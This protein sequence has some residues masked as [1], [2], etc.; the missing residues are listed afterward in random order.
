MPPE[1]DLHIHNSLAQTQ[2]TGISPN[3]SLSEDMIPPPPPPLLGT[4]PISQ[5]TYANRLQ[6]DNR[7][8][9]PPP[10]Q[11]GMTQPQHYPRFTDYLQNESRE[12]Q[13]RGHVYRVSNPAPASRSNSRI[14]KDGGPNHPGGGTANRKTVRFS[15]DSKNGGDASPY[16]DTPQHQTNL[17]PTPLRAVP[18]NYVDC[19]LLKSI[20]MSGKQ[21][22]GS[23]QSM[24][25]QGRDSG[26]SSLHGLSALEL[27]S[28][29]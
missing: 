4:Y 26:L 11:A 16:N 19:D 29:V 14:A 25:S 3:D 21:N 27:D 28:L 5:A 15:T 12:L 20:A 9:P 24:P 1:A 2:P 13:Q 18:N 8:F 17:D 10:P 7:P 23:N 22:M 6:P